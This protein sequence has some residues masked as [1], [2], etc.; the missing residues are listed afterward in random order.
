MSKASTGRRKRVERNIYER[1]SAEGRKVLEVGYRDS[2]GRQRWR[3]VEGGI[4]AARTVRDDLLARRGRGE[5]V[6]P[7]PRLRFEQ[8][9]DAWL[10][11][12]VADLRPAT[13]A[14]YRNAVENHL[15]PQWGRR[16][17]EAISVDDVARL[18][19]DL[20]DEGKSEWTIA[21]VL[22]AANRIFKFSKRRLDWHGESPVAGLDSSERPSTATTERRRIYRGNELG[23]TLA[24]A[25]EPYKTLFALASVTGARLSECLGL[26]WGDLSVNDLEAAEIR[27]EFQ[28]D[29]K[30][31][32]Q[33]LKTEES[34]RT[35]EIPRQLAVMLNAHCL[36]S[37][38][39]GP[40]DFVF[41]TRTGNA[42][43]QRNVTRAL[44]RIQKAAADEL[45]RPTFPILHEVDAE[46]EPMKVSRGAV[47]NFHSFRHSAASEAIAQGDSAEEV[48][49]QLGHRNSTVTRA[50]YVQE[51]KSAERKARRRANMEARY[52]DLLE[53]AAQDEP[54]QANR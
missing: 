19:R 24:A 5:R 51:I 21:G 9:A 53:T 50:V 48:S 38:L 27:F 16:R 44:R 34:R 25:T 17:L 39:T 14:G 12:Q 4:R 45:G 8:A 41:A 6:Q 2:G 26:V 3:T 54:E 22:K 37:R 13:Q 11:E 7:N 43:E 49:W 30:G 47:P 42:I 46:D 1:T 28:V 52:G 40:T 35:V 18:V 32:R 15:N 29:R 23:Q 36:A 10:T 31:Q 20:R 33:P